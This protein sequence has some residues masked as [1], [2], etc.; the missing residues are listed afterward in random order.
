MKKFLY[1]VLVLLMLVPML[2]PAVSASS[3]NITVTNNYETLTVY[4]TGYTLFRY[5]DLDEI[6]I[7]R[8]DFAGESVQTIGDGADIIAGVSIRNNVERTVIRIVYTYENG[9]ELTLYY[10]RDDCR[11]EY[12]RIISR[13]AEELILAFD[14][15]DEEDDYPI[16]R[17]V[18][19]GET[20]TLHRTEISFANYTPVSA[21]SSD[22]VYSVM[23]GCIF[24]REGEYFYADAAESGM[25]YPY[26]FEGYR[27][28]SSFPAHRITDED[29]ISVLDKNF[30]NV[31]YGTLYEDDTSDTISVGFFGFVFG[32]VPLVLC[33]L[34]LILAILAKGE[35]RKLYGIIAALSAAELSVFATVTALILM[36]G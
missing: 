21:F 25:E 26:S 15:W 14:R 7:N 18:L 23:Y 6:S 5:S 16:R 4:G 19:M 36:L 27:A 31:D 2:C 11:A 28:L 33:V 8:S 32:F 12:E 22:G 20:V 9:M 10:L 1:A 13:K 3:A 29:L 17:D 34:F 35:Y 30:D 24:V